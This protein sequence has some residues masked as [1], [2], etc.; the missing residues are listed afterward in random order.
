MH[1]F[2][3]PLKSENPF[4]CD[5]SEASKDRQVKKFT[6]K[7]DPSARGMYRWQVID[8]HAFKERDSTL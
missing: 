7:R 4:D 3:E 8:S 6:P 2:I 1:H 5:H